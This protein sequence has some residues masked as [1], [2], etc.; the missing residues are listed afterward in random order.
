MATFEEKLAH[1]CRV[2]SVSVAD[3]CEATGVKPFSL[4]LQL[5][6]QRRLSH[7]EMLLLCQFFAVVDDYFINEAIHYVD[8]DELPDILRELMHKP[9]NSKKI[10][11]Y[12]EVTEEEADFY[13]RVFEDIRFFST[14]KNK[15][16]LAI[17]SEKFQKDF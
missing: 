6:G 5:T 4:H 10:L 3:V 16:P 8:E 13:D 12:E 17:L 1:A 2:F 9:K 15:V 14:R 11:C 7:D